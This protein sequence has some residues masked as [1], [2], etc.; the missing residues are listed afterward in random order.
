MENE[1]E[2]I[3]LEDPN[4]EGIILP[5]VDEEQEEQ[6]E[7]EEVIEENNESEDEEDGFDK[8]ALL[9]ALNA[10]RKER[11]KLQKQLK[12]STKSKETTKEKSTYD[13]LVEKGVDEELAK[14]LSEAIDK[15][16]DRVAELQFN[17]D[18]LR[19]SRKPGFEDIEDYSDEIRPFV[20]K[21]LTIEQAY[22]AATG[23]IKKSS[24]TKSEIK[25]ELEAKMKNQ[26]IKSSVNWVFKLI[27]NQVD[28]LY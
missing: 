14:T 9:K 16:D 24:N 15:P 1:Q 28:V 4:E 5:E 3:L 2:G 13:T 23:G 22:Y 27:I 10:E 7:N 12:E 19:V 11:K 26:K 18:L 6:E 20:D 25:R 17:N 21:G 8:E